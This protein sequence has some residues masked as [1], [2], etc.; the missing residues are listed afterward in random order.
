MSGRRIKSLKNFSSKYKEELIIFFKIKDE[1]I[2]V[3]RLVK[4][5]YRKFNQI[6]EVD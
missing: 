5:Y 4:K 6:P 2:N 3:Y 1:K